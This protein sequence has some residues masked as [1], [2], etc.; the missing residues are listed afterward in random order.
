MD[1]R[2]NKRPGTMRLLASI[3]ASSALHCAVLFLFTQYAGANPKL[4]FLVTATLN[5]APVR[6]DQLAYTNSHGQALSVSRL[7]LLLSDFG[8]RTVDGRWSEQTNWQ[9][10]LSLGSGRSQFSIS[11]LLTARIDRIRFH[12]GLRPEVN[13]S[14]PAQ[15]VP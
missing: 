1:S 15:Y 10:W 11:N 12:I 5:E 8:L 2:S 9:A 3:L 4:D 14:N 7:D 6:F 13:H